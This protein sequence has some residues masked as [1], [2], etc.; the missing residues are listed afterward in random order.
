MTPDITGLAHH[1]N[2]AR[3]DS[4]SLQQAARYY[5]AEVSDYPTPDEMRAE[6]SAVAPQATNA[7]DSAV[8]ALT[9]D[10]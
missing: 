7:V 10:P 2:D 1:L 3:I 6:L 5:I 4:E 8:D 9:R